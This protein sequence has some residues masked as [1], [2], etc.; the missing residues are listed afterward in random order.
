MQ[1][2]AH[3]VKRVTLRHRY[4]TTK[5][6]HSRRTLRKIH[7]MV[8]EAGVEE[9]VEMEAEV[10]QEG[11]EDHPTGMSRPTTTTMMKCWKTTHLT[12]MT[13]ATTTTGHA[14]HIEP[15]A[16]QV[17]GSQDGGNQKYEGKHPLATTGDNYPQC[18]IRRGNQPLRILAPQ[19]VKTDTMSSAYAS[20]VASQR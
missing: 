17:H 6:T 18:A 7:L 13:R 9:E 5:L 3:Q 8:V 14:Q 11:P 20:R 2:P 15:P 12:S 16:H 19:P 10:D 4:A 1:T